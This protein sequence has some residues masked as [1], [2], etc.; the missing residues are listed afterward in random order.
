MRVS[1][2]LP[3]AILGEKLPVFRRISED[4]RS[5]WTSLPCQAHT[6]ATTPQLPILDIITTTATSLEIPMIIADYD[7]QTI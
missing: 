5:M 7:T 1:L 2:R 3:T 6:T 4:A